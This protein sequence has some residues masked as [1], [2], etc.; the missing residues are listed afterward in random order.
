[1]TVLL[2]ILLTTLVMIS[3]LPVAFGLI[4]VATIM[5]LLKDV[6]LFMV[7]QNLLGAIDNFVLVS[8]PMFLFMSNILLK[9][10]V[11]RSLFS[12][13]QAWV[14]HLPGGLAIATLL[15][16]GVFSAINGSSVATAATIGSVAIPEMSSR[17]YPQRFAVGMVAAGGTLGILI[18][19]S[20][21]L[22]VYGVITEQSIGDLFLA[23]IGPG[24][25]LVILFGIYAYV[26]ARVTK[27]MAAT[28]KA[29]WPER[30][31][32]TRDALPVLVLAL[33][34]VGGIYGGI[35]TPTEAAAAGV[36][37]A[38]LI[39][40][41]WLKTLTIKG[42]WQ[43][44]KDALHTTVVI[45]LVVAGAKLL[46]QAITIYQIPNEITAIVSQTIA[47]KEFFLVV[48]ALILLAVGCFLEPISIILIFVP[49][50]MPAV[51]HFGMDPIFL[52][53]FFVLMVEIGLITPPIGLNLFVIQSIS[54]CDF[55]TAT[56]GA[57]PFV[58]IMLF[59]TGILV[60]A[61]WIALAIPFG[62]F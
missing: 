48:M 9:G 52:G 6:S 36:G 1:M 61:P 51:L 62:G 42:L 41:F 57:I 56:M 24:I 34:I 20:I 58:I 8:I 43:S 40:K 37:L 44:A 33:A 16:C 27:T 26:Y 45:L 30:I 59:G 4:A 3:G 38:I 21:P 10:G 22:I 50:F 32:A 31:S 49:V 39:T 12:A 13:T 23:G 46:S 7:T 29:S 25:L 54:K 15:S 2:I 19:P 47:S 18:P 53:I 35:F 11:G 17:G 5:L 14:G 55:K 28:P 60:A